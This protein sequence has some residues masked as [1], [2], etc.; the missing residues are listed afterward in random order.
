MALD[1]MPAL[2]AEGIGFLAEVGVGFPAAFVGL[3][4]IAFRAPFC[5]SDEQ[6]FEVTAESLQLTADLFTQFLPFAF[7]VIFPLLELSFLEMLL[8]FSPAFP[9]KFLMKPIKEDCSLRS[10]LKGLL[11]TRLLKMLRSVVPLDSDLTSF[12]EPLESSSS[13]AAD[14][15]DNRRILG[16]SDI[17]GLLPHCKLDLSVWDPGICL[18]TFAGLGLNGLQVHPKIK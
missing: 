12:V 18:R 13:A 2:G 9:L 1:L 15:G 7:S 4:S 8:L 16:N 10:T 5:A 6:A 14:P 3:A 11:P 17:E